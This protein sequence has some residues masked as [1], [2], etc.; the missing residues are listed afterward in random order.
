MERCGARLAVHLRV[1][2][3]MDSRWKK[4]TC[5]RRY[6]SFLHFGTRTRIHHHHRVSILL[7]SSV[8][9]I[10][11]YWNVV[12]VHVEFKEIPARLERLSVVQLI[13][14]HWLAHVP[15][16]HGMVRSYQL[17]ARI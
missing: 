3:C 1:P 10:L 14:G 5:W 12:H 6:I 13:L 15:I 17:S 16:Q 2:R 9:R 7:P 11:L 4:R 8:H